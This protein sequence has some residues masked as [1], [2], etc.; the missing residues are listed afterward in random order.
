MGHSRPPRV[1]RSAEVAAD[2][3]AGAEDQYECHNADD[4]CPPRYSAPEQ[5]LSRRVPCLVRERSAHVIVPCQNRPQRS[6][7]GPYSLASHRSN[8]KA[9]SGGHETTSSEVERVRRFAPLGMETS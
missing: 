2:Y 8:V 4:S 1:R 3:K 5:V 6:A 9:E 7:H